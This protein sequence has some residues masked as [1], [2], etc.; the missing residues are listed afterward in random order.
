MGN[1]ISEHLSREFA[2]DIKVIL[3]DLKKLLKVQTLYPDENPL[4]AKMRA[5]FGGRFVEV[6]DEFGGLIFSIHPEEIVYEGEVVYRDESREEA[7]AADFYNTGIIYLEFR[8]GLSIDEFHIFLDILKTYQRDRLEADDLVSLLW[9]EQFVHVRFKT[10]DDL[11][12]GEVETESLIHEMYPSFDPNRRNAYRFDHNRIILD[13]GKSDSLPGSSL[14][15]GTVSPE[16]SED[17]SKMGLSLESSEE[18]QAPLDGLLSETFLTADEEQE[19]I[20]RLLEENRRYD[21]D[22]GSVRILIEIL[23]HWDDRGKFVK[24]VDICE[25]ALDQYLNRG[26]FKAAADLVH[27]V[28][29]YRDEL[30]VTKPDYASRLDKFILH[31][32]DAS[33][34]QALT[35]I[36]NMQQSI[37]SDLI[38][39]YLDCLGWESLTHVTGMLGSLVSRQARLRVCDYLSRRGHDHINIIANG[40]RDQRWYV[41]RNSVMILGRIGG[42][43]VLPYLNKAAG[44]GD[45]RVRMEVLRAAA[46]HDDDEAVDIMFG[47]LKDEDIKIREAALERLRQTGGRRSFEII[48][49][50]VRSP[51]FTDYPLDEQEQF[52]IIYSSL[53]GAEITD[54]LD[55]IIGSFSLFNLGWKARY[56]FM[57]LKALAHNTSDEAERLILKYTRSR[58]KWLRQAAAAALD[59]RRRVLFQIRSEK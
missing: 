6:V 46:G 18:N 4:P 20:K 19:E 53:G 27:N 30:S 25:K 29:S 47:F 14:G 45:N 12:L 43:Q 35:N 28:R 56:R 3:R 44:H 24:T 40:L 16:A 33:R 32:G 10:V 58:R 38:E 13:E 7:L 39:S 34:I 51:D 31:C 9:Q 37:D 50:I 17:A 11:A 54:F 2:S 42:R 41:V 36:I 57:A 49:Q 5:S 26:A 21:P 59:T 22:R 8:E 23:H 48:Q 55:S 1:V 15:A 52:L